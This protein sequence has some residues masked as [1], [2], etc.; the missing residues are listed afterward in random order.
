MIWYEALLLNK[1]V[2]ELHIFLYYKFNIFWYL[3]IRLK[4]YFK[5]FVYSSELSFLIFNYFCVIIKELS[6]DFWE[7]IL[8]KGIWAF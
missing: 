5:I 3:I 8:Y 7:M 4:D 6:K 2:K 1:S